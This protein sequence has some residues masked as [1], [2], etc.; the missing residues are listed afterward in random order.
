MQ[1]QYYTY[2]HL[3]NTIQQPRCRGYRSVSY[4]LLLAALDKG[5]QIVNAVLSPSWDQNGFVYVVSLRH[6]AC[7]VHQE[8]ILPQDSLTESLLQE[9]RSSYPVNE[10]ATCSYA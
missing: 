2:E 1:F 9:T 3:W 10:P 4:L 5:W 6:P 8:L 7:P